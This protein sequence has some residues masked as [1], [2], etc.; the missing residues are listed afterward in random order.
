[1]KTPADQ[2][3]KL[4]PDFSHRRSVLGDE[5]TPFIASDTVNRMVE[6]SIN[7]LRLPQDQF[8]KED[9][10]DSGCRL[11]NDIMYFSLEAAIDEINDIR[12]VVYDLQK[13]LKE[14]KVAKNEGVK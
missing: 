8:A 7:I 1:M 14:N 3:P 6:K 13:I 5:A 10:E 4:N 12:A 11:N 9:S 2:T